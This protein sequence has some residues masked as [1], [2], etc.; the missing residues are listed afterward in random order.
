VHALKTL[1]AAGAV[2]LL[3]ACAADTAEDMAVERAAIDAGADEALAE[4]YRDVPR[5]QPLGADA[6]GILIFP[7]VVKAGLVGVT[8]ETGDGVLRVGGES[9]AYY[10]TTAAGI[11]LALGAQAYSKVLM[12]MTEEALSDFRECSGWEAGVD[13]SVAVL[14]VDASGQLDTDSIQSDIVA[15]IY[16]AEGLMGNLTV[17]GSKYTLKAL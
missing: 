12:F 13:G 3:A 2:T 17:E 10:D 14:N 1:I 16:G 4:L 5:A 8:G 9:V 7:N 15:F 11:G 6:A